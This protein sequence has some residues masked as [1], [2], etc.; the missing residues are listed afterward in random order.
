MI[1]EHRFRVRYAET[2]A[3]RIAHHAVY[4]IWFEAGRVEFL[5]SLGF[6]FPELEASGL[7]QA[8]Y[9]LRLQYRRPARFD[10]LLALR[11][12]LVSADG[13]RMTFAYRLYDAGEL[14]GSGAAAAPLVLGTTEMV[15][16]SQEGRPVRLPP[17]HPL[18]LVL[19]SMERHPEWDEW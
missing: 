5:R 18:A 19:A 13:P 9:N 4:L 15:W 12:A 10:Q 14:D 6:Q 17:T 7:G 11:I 1:Y 3:M 8:V 16:V 2:D